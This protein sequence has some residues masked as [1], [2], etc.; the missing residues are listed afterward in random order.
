[1][2]RRALV[3]GASGFAAPFLIREL[4]ANGREEVFGTTHAESPEKPEVGYETLPL[5]V[6]DAEAVRRVVSETRPDE[7]YHLAGVTRPAS[8]AVS[9]FHAVN[10]GGALNLLEAVKSE[11]PETPVLLVGSAYAYGR[12]DRKIA[13]DTPLAPMNHYG[14]SKASAE[15]LGKV[16]ALEGMRV[17]LARPFNHSGPGQSPDFL[18]PTLVEQFAAIKK[19]EREPVVKLGNLDSVRDLS[20]VR[21]VVRAYRLMLEK[22]ESKEAYNAASGRGVSVRETFDLVREASGAEVELEV[23]ESRVRASDIPYLVASV[24]KAKRNLGWQPEIPLE[25]TVREMVEEALEH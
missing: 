17:V 20:D 25:R 4:L 5:D 15:M 1:M 11:T 2:S 8:G 7:V 14:L 12:V 6:T 13:E 22:G 21:D 18:L 3:T 19:G 16:Y 9:E 23:E 10:F 24:E